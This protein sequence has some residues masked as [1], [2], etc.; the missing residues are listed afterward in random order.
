MDDYWK[1]PARLRDR[2]NEFKHYDKLS[3]ENNDRISE[4]SDLEYRISELEYKISH[5][6]S[7]N[8]YL[9]NRTENLENTLEKALDDI[10]DIKKRLQ[11]KEKAKEIKDSQQTEPTQSTFTQPQFPYVDVDYEYFKKKKGWF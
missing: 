10:S 4:I 1:S 7:R 9:E 2:I 8:E 6:E 11:E 5:L 3:G